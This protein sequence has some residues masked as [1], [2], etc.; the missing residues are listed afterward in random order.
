MRPPSLL[1]SGTKGETS[2]ERTSGK[3]GCRSDLGVFKIRICD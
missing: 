3:A 1:S 2:S